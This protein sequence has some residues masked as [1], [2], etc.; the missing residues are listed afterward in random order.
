MLLRGRLCLLREPGRGFFQY[1]P[2]FTQRSHLAT[3]L[4][5]F[6]TLFGRETIGA[7]AVV[8]IRLA[9]PVPDRLGRGFKLPSQFLG[10]LAGAHQLDQ[11]AAKLR[12]IWRWGCGLLRHR[13]TLRPKWS[14]VHETGSTPPCQRMG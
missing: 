1:L 3:Q 4:A 11:A 5:E 9:D 6:L 14:A 10:T 13:G 2:L 8:E 12:R 7:L